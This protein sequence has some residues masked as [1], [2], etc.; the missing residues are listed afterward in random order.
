MSFCSHY[1]LGFPPSFH[2]HKNININE[3]AD[4]FSPIN[5][6]SVSV[7]HKSLVTES[8]KEEEKH[9]PPLQRSTYILK[10]K[11]EGVLSIEEMRGR[12]ARDRFIE[13]GGDAYDVS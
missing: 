5:L 6:S 13:V 9:F 10:S 1:F 2:V 8:E 7:I 12:K 11:E 3:E 4:A